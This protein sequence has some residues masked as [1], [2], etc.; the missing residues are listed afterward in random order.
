MSILL[1]S[2]DIS[3]VADVC[4]RIGVLYAGQRNPYPVRSAHAA[5]SVADLESEF[6]L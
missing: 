2:H 4:D 5:R 1:I 3:V 6:E